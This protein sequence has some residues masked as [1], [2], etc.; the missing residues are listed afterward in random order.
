MAK[1]IW[2]EQYM[3]LWNRYGSH[4]QSGMNLTG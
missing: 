2:D 4:G 3:A 1:T